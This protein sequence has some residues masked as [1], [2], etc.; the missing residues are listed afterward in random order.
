MVLTVLPP[1]LSRFPL[2]IGLLDV[3]VGFTGVES[4]TTTVVAE[5]EVQL[6]IVSVTL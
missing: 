2:H 1:R 4:T 3:T 5:G 6:A